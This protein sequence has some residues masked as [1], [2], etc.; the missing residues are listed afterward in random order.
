MKNLNFNL[1]Y[2]AKCDECEKYTHFYRYDEYRFS[3]I[4]GWDSLS[5][6]MCWRCV[7]KEKIRH[8]KYKIKK[9]YKKECKIFTLF[10][11]TLK[12]KK[13]GIFKHYTIIRKSI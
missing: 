7:I 1:H 4:D 6:T 9:Q 12:H 8:A 10:F 2:L 3:T 11:K 5:Y 13:G